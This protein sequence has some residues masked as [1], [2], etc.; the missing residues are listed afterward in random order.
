MRAKI[1]GVSVNSILAA[2]VINRGSCKSSRFGLTIST[3]S[4][5]SYNSW[6][7]GLTAKV[8]VQIYYDTLST[9]SG[10]AVFEGLADDIAV[11]PINGVCRVQGRDYSSLLIGSNNQESYS[12]RTAS[13]IVASIAQRHGFDTNIA[14]TYGMVGSYQGN[15]HNQILLNT[16]SDIANEW[17]LLVY[18][19]KMERF[20]LFVDARELVF[21]PLQSLAREQIAVG[22]NDI[23]SM[24]TM[25]KCPLSDKTLLTVK[26]WNSW[27]TRTFVHTDSQLSEQMPSTNPTAFGDPDI[28]VTFVRPNLSLT[29]VED[30]S[31]E[32]RRTSTEQLLNIEIVMPGDTTMKPGDILSIQGIGVAFD[33]DYIVK[34]VRRTFSSS[35]GFVQYIHGFENPSS[36]SQPATAPGL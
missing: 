11:D 8:I 24:K 12:N 5:A 28:G 14:V 34:S 21:S 25:R 35:A 9:E 30:L 36:S 13:E 26:S 33:S 29:G 15:D 16:H 17:E 4:D 23:I 7:G 22:R 27:L 19:A 32:Y 6:L 1:N 31:R 10:Y 2:E 18:L 20:E 3:R